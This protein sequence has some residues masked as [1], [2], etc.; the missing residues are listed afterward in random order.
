MT[1]Q[2]KDQRKKKEFSQNNQTDNQTDSQKE[3]PSSGGNP[4]NQVPPKKN[5]SKLFIL[6]MAILGVLFFYN[7]F[8]QTKPQD[9]VTF[10]DFTNLVESREVSEVIIQDEQAK[11]ITNQDGRTLRTVIPFYYKKELG[12][13]LF[14]EGV[15]FKYAAGK[16]GNLFINI[17]ATWLPVLLIVGVWVFIFRQMQGGNKLVNVGQSVITSIDRS[18]IKTTFNDIAGVE[19][20]KNE[21]MDIVHFLKDT[22]KFLSIGGR[23]PT[24][25]LLCGSPGTGKTLLARA[26]A[27][28]AD[29][30][31]FS[32]SGSS[33][34]EMFVGVGS[35]RVRDLF[36]KARASRPSII[37]IDE[38]DAIGRQR[39]SGLG[40]G[41]DEREQTLNQLL[42]EMDGFSNQEGVIVIA[43][44]NRPDVLD[45]A[46]TRPGRFDR[47]VIVP[48]PDLAGR[49]KI[50]QVHT[51]N[52]KLA[53]NV[54][55]DIV[56]KST[57]GMTGASLANLANEAALM[58]GR[59]KK[60]TVNQED[61]EFAL[62]KLIMG[63]ARKSMKITAE[64]KEMTA[65]H[66]AGHAL[67]AVAN[68]YESILHKVTIVPH[69]QAL[70]VTLFLPNEDQV[71]VTRK[72]LLKSLEMMMGGRAAEDVIYKNF[73]T[74]AS[75]DLE[76][77]S[78]LAYQMVCNW[79]MGQGIGP[80]Y[81]ADDNEDVFLGKQLFKKKLMGQKTAV[82]VDEEVQNILN[83]AYKNTTA[84]LKKN[85]KT[86]RQ[87]AK[88]L[89]EKET[90]DGKWV[91]AAFK[92]NQTA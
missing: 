58:A 34:V 24:G 61:F 32:I 44:T 90:I 38:I 57:T 80:V 25:I 17:L 33:F 91:A 9:L 26:I 49:K 89:M 42:V 55:L 14:Q 6:G 67:A 82:V 45:S 63:P 36:N 41:N 77:A 50:L 21:V 73:S 70:G 31:F 65:M 39:G 56:A 13:Y 83:K 48:L 3:H 11:F 51:K 52:I 28:E 72:H 86:L 62:E 22:Q 59:M 10:S 19:E 85:I 1:G 20:A 78:Q 76:R 79:G 5:Y 84:I 54:N 43:A 15:K 8:K 35:S 69:S 68:K 81:L 27:G 53:K 74:G 66:E 37:F 40:G 75:N 2:N 29:A 46:L 92:K 16:G 64:E 47:Q 87:V 60:S 7:V 12:K 71:Y 30:S 23:V 18:K 88:E 4:N